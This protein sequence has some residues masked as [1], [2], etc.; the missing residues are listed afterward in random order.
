[1]PKN[2]REIQLVYKAIYFVRGTDT[3]KS[4]TKYIRSH[5]HS[6]ILQDKRE[7]GA[8]IYI[9]LCSDRPKTY[10]KMFYEMVFMLKVSMWL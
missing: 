9:K 2:T 8:S 1:M 10:L 7:T 5:K 4:N 3:V 6:C